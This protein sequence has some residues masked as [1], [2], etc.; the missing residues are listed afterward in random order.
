[1]SYLIGRLIMWY[2]AAGLW[3]ERK[4][5]KQ[6]VVYDDPTPEELDVMYQD[7]EKQM[8]WEVREAE[9][10]RRDYPLEDRSDHWDEGFG[11]D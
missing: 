5:K 6:E 3:I 7:Y 4:F 8:D 1:M 11:E 9:R 10:I 2:M